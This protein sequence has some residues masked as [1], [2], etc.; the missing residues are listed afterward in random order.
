[1]CTILPGIS[2]MKNIRT[3]INSSKLYQGGIFEVYT[4]IKLQE[5]LGRWLN[6]LC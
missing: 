5:I 6:R 1:M 4:Y 2:V 3:I